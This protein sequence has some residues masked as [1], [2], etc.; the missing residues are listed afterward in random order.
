VKEV[1]ADDKQF[2]SYAVGDFNSVAFSHSIGP[3]KGGYHEL[4]NEP[5]GMGERFTDE[6]IAWIRAH[7]PGERSEMQ[8]KL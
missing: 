3:I 4:V 5:D 2:S 1:E 8:A 6:V 7:L